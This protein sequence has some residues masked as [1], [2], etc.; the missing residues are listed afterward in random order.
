M[1][2]EMETPR[3]MLRLARDARDLR[4]AQRLRYRVFVQELGA[5]GPMV[6][7]VEGLERDR[8]DPH[9][10]HLLL[11]DPCRDPEALEDVVGVYRLLPGERAEAAGGFYSVGE[12]DLAPLLASGRRLL[13]LGRTCIDRDY[14]GGG[15][16]YQMWAGLADY[17]LARRIEVMFGT[18]S[19]HGAD[20]APIAT[21]LA[22]LHNFHLAPPEL[23][24]RVRAD[25][26]VS[27]DTLAPDRIDR[28]AAFQSIPA[29]IKSYLRLGGF[30][31]EGAFVDHAFNTT[32]VL[33]ILD[34]Q[35]ITQRQL[36]ALTRPGAG[37][38]PA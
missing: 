2:N 9:C 5:D 26:G 1:P 11:V 36:E 3:L 20:P 30:V 37:G 23:R 29:L 13:E 14:R 31:G 17:A 33:L 12:Y 32:D 34:T 27:M 35:R 38:D 21:A 7:H 24:A 19:F 8:F 15:A 18:A 28:R 25:G 22:Y 4:A 16:L 6:D 10:D